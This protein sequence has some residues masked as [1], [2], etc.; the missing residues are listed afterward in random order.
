MAQYQGSEFIFNFNFQP[1]P[2]N[3]AIDK[4]VNLLYDLCILRK[5]KRERDAREA[6]VREAL[7]Q[8]TSEDA[9]TNALYSVVRGD[10]SIDTFIA[11]KCYNKTNKGVM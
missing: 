6:A 3:V 8:Y 7:S 10:K 1:D 4:K 9:L 11:Q 2:I 5:N